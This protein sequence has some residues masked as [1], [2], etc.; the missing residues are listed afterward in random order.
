VR[1]DQS[2]AAFVCKQLSKHVALYATAGPNKSIKKQPIT[3]LLYRQGFFRLRVGKPRYPLALGERRGAT[4]TFPS[5][6][7]FVVYID[8]L[9]SNESQ[10]SSSKK[11]SAR[12][13]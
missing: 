5:C 12:F 6:Y 7:H 10:V 3:F 2:I 8:S 9:F 4:K 13:A 11:E 1:A